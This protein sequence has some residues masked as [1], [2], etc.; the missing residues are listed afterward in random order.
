MR[1]RR[2]DRVTGREATVYT[3]PEDVLVITQPADCV[4]D[5]LHT[6]SVEDKIGNE[7]LALLISMERQ[8]GC[9]AEVRALTRILAAR[10]VS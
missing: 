4:C 5:G 3:P 10:S 9:P 7:S 2:I 8:H 1:T 6:A